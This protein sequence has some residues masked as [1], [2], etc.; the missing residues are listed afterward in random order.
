[1]AGEESTGMSIRGHVPEKDGTL[2]CLLVAELAASTGKLLSDI[3]REMQQTYGL[4]LSVRGDHDLSE[5]LVTRLRAILSSTPL[6]AAGHTALNLVTA[7]G[8]KWLFENS[9]WVHLPLS[10]TEPVARLYVE[11]SDQDR[12]ERIEK[13]FSI[14]FIGSNG[15]AANSLVEP[16]K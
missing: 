8:T 5:E 3:N 1:M 15:T 14:W 12:L 6:E 10:G 9:D 16:G 7:D 2:A 4:R 13:A 11:A